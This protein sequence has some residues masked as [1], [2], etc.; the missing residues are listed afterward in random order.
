MSV[1]DRSK[2]PHV[3]SDASGP[4]TPKRGGF[5]EF[6]A[7]YRARWAMSH[8]NMLR[9]WPGDSALPLALPNAAEPIPAVIAPG[10]EM[11]N[12]GEQT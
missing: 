4:N 10:R 6:S 5:G 2:D 3:P 7:M 8:P 9:Q 11:P 12:D 1:P